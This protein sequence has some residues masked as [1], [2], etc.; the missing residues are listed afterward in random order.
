MPMKP[1]TLKDTACAMYDP[2]AE[3]GIKE[4]LQN[5]AAR[6]TSGA[7]T[8]R[9]KAG[10]AIRNK[11][12]RIASEKVSKMVSNRLTS[13][14]S[15]AEPKKTPRKGGKQLPSVG[16]SA[17]S[18][19]A[20]FAKE[21][22]EKKRNRVKDAIL[23]RTTA[24]KVVRGAAVLGAAALAA[25]AYGK[26]KKREQVNRKVRIQEVETMVR[27]GRRSGMH[28]DDAVAYALSRMPKKKKGIFSSPS[29]TARFS[30]LGSFPLKPK[31]SGVVGAIAGTKM[32]MAGA[33]A[34]KQAKGGMAVA[35]T[36]VT[37][38]ATNAA[39]KVKK[40]FNGIKKPKM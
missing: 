37:L 28:T 2:N 14:N 10:L 34:V 7:K 23:G 11:A 27:E 38:A 39:A 8:L 35:K 20:L 19:T 3:F 18:G 33:S 15:F 12:I 32:G 40:V 4:G 6:V 26:N 22:K 24:G 13:Q 21:E 31:K 5:V 16:F 25:K 36:K 17:Y 1:I 9:R 30:T 29:S